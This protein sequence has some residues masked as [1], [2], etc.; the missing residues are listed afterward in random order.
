MPIAEVLVD[1]VEY[2]LTVVI[3]VGLHI[4]SSDSM[5]HQIIISVKG[6]AIKK[7]KMNLLC[8]NCEFHLLLIL[9]GIFKKLP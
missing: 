4:T 9:L 6:L 7:A 5:L 8:F 3:P 1:Q 2:R